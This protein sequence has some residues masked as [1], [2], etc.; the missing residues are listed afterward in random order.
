MLQTL[1]WTTVALTVTQ[2]TEG[3]GY[4]SRVNLGTSYGPWLSGCPRHPEHS[5]KS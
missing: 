3:I 4:E 2:G 5:R 1:L